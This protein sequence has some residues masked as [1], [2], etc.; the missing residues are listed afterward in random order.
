MGI[1]VLRPLVGFACS[2]VVF[3]ELLFPCYTCVNR[4]DPSTGSLLQR[5]VRPYKRYSLMGVHRSICC[6]TVVLLLKL[7]MSFHV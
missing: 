4:D 6:G 1:D 2:V 7:I 3:N 5:C